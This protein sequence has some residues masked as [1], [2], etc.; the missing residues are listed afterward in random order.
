MTISEHIFYSYALENRMQLFSI[1]IHKLNMDGTQDV[2][3]Q[4]LPQLTYTAEDIQN[5]ARAWTGFDRSSIRANAESDYYDLN[6]FD[7]MVIYGPWRDY[8]PKSDLLGG[9]IGDRYPLCTDIPEKHFLTQGATYRLIGSSK[10]PLLHTQRD[11]WFKRGYSIRT[12]EL[13]PST[14]LYG[15][16][17]NDDGGGCNFAP[18]VTLDANISCNAD[19]PECSV[20]DLRLVKVGSNPDIH[21][22]YV[23]AACVEHT[24]YLNSKTVQHNNPR[25]AMCANANLPL[26]METCCE[27]PN[28][29]IPKA[30]T[31]CAYSVEKTTF[32]TSASRC[33]NRFEHGEQDMCAWARQSDDDTDGDCHWNY[34]ENYYWASPASCILQAKGELS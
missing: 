32:Y 9:Y 10:N 20:D 6:H 2:D 33:A 7:P 18:V 21:Y 11:E 22:E 31:F 14:E 13:S 25:V 5:F 15:K 19:D 12:L 8:S 23:R 28:S 26:A 24:F 3:A 27:E 30:R 17:C 4:G 29:S 34:V 16:L 1:G